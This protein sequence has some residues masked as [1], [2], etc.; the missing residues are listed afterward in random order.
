MEEKMNKIPES[1][2]ENVSG[3]AGGTAHVQI[4]GC[5]RSCNVRAQASTDSTLLGTASL[6]DRYVFYGWHGSWAK[7]KY[8]SQTAYIYKRFIKVL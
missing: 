1:E 6:G 8:G 7:V 4:I 3:G 5:K 2:L